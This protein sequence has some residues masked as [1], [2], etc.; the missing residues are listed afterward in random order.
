MVLTN[1]REPTRGAGVMKV[2][3]TVV[4]LLALHAGIA[5]G[6]P[7]ASAQDPSQPPQTGSVIPLERVGGTPGAI[8]GAPQAPTPAPSMQGDRS[9]I[10]PSPQA[11]VSGGY[12]G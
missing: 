10:L 5:I 1:L 4:V 9:A 7:V 11:H 8:G 3:R 2:E 6:Q 12:G